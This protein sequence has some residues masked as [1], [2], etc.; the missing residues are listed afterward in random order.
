MDM[1]S[2]DSAPWPVV[3]IFTLIGCAMLYY[4]KNFFGKKREQPDGQ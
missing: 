3:L 1:E 4:F 2:T